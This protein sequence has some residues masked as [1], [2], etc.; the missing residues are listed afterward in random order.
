[1]CHNAQ[2]TNLANYKFPKRY[3]NKKRHA[4]NF[5]H[6]SYLKCRKRLLNIRGA[7]FYFML[8]VAKVQPY[9]HLPNNS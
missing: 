3:L 2:K 6:A 1:M 8:I 7:F 5:M 9:L 4:D